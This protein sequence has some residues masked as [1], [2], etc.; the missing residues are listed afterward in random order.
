VNAEVEDRPQASDRFR[1][2][3]VTDRPRFD[4]QDLLPKISDV[5]GGDLHDLVEQEMA[6][7][8][9]AIE[10]AAQRIEAL[11]N[12]ARKKDSGVNLEVNER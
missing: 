11:L 1:F 6:S 2:R 3:H 12:E 4:L 5:K 7:T 9:K 8:S 10:Q